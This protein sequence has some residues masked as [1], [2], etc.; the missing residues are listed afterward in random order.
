M[1]QSQRGQRAKADERTESISSVN[2]AEFCIKLKL[3]N[4]QCTRLLHSTNDH[5]GLTHTLGQ[6]MKK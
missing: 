2:C 1:Q 4:A 3:Y 5:H 6:P